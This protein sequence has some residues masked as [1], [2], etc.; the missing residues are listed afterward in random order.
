MENMEYWEDRITEFQHQTVSKC[1]E[2]FE[3]SSKNRFEQDVL[4]DALTQNGVDAEE[5]D[6]IINMYCECE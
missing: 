1:I 6:E 3:N 5:A 4:Y 2:L